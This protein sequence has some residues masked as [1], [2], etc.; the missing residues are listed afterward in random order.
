MQSE[1]VQFQDISN[2]YAVYKYKDFLV[3]HPSAQISHLSGL[4]KSFHG[5]K[6]DLQVHEKA[7]G[8]DGGSVHVV[9]ILQVI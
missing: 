2:F 1:H 8:T 7:E 3:R 4:T 9:S 5:S 6:W